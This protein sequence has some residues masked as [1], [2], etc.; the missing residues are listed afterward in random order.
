MKKY[1]IWILL[2]IGL[3]FSAI[4][5]QAYSLTTAQQFL[6]TCQQPKNMNV[7]RAYISGVI[8]DIFA[9][10]SINDHHNSRVFTKN[11][12]NLDAEKIRI[13]LLKWANENPQEIKNKSAASMINQFLYSIYVKPT[14]LPCG[15]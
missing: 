11:M 3:L 10:Y 12:Q 2:S 6:I 1:L 9:N 7:C 4:N 15:G 8:D 14:A 13:A 5:A